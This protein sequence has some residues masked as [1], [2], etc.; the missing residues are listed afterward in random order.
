MKGRE[1][2]SIVRKGAFVG[3]SCQKQ[4]KAKT[5]AKGKSKKRKG[6]KRSK[7]TL[8]GWETRRKKHGKSG[9]TKAKRAK[10]KSAKKRAAAK[11]KK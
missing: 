7:A 3:Y 8:K 5:M 11:R 6:T 9:R 1:N 4:R 2:H 10:G